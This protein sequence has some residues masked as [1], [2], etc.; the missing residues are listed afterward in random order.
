M[1]TKI[2]S[3]TPSTISAA[4][5][6]KALIASGNTE[7]PLQSLAESLTIEQVS[8][9]IGLMGKSNLTTK[10]CRYWLGVIRL[11]DTDLI[12]VV[13]NLK[14]ATIELLTALAGTLPFNTR[15]PNGA[16]EDAWLK[17][18]KH[19]NIQISSQHQELLAYLICRGLSYISPQASALLALTFDMVHSLISNSKLKQDAWYKIEQF[20]PKSR[21]FFEWDRCERLRRGIA[22]TL[23]RHNVPANEFILIS[24]SDYN[25]SQIVKEIKSYTGGKVYLN[26]LLKDPSHSPRKNALISE[27]LYKKY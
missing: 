26:S 11:E 3:A 24:A 23:V 18:I 16:T 19:S 1:P 25:F 4:S 9:L 12:N 5:V 17:S 22:E 8:Y 21:T 14:S 6:F 10:K 27:V 20:L 13:S 7:L 15:N 2:L